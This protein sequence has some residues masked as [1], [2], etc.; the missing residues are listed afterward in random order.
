MK[1][2][3]KIISFPKI[4]L[5]PLL[6]SLAATTWSIRLGWDRPALLAALAVFMTAISVS[7]LAL[8]KSYYCRFKE[9]ATEEIKME[10]RQ[11]ELDRQH[12]L[13]L[14]H[15]AL[16]ATIDGVIVLSTDGKIINCNRQFAEMWNIS[17]EILATWSGPK[18]LGMMCELMSD[19]EEFL[20]RTGE[21]DDKCAFCGHH[22]CEDCKAVA[23]MTLLK[24]GRVI[25]YCSRPLVVEEKPAGR[26]WSFHDITPQ[27]LAHRA[28]QETN[29][30]LEAASGRA[31]EMALKA[32]MAS[33]AKSQFLANMSHEI[34]TPM[35][36]II[37]MT[38][39]L[40]Q[41]D[42]TSEQ[43][44]FARLLKSSGESLLALI[45]DILDF[46]KIEAQKLTL[47]KLD[48]NLRETMEEAAELL[49]FK[50]TEKNL[51]L[52]CLIPPEVPLF[53]RGDAL[54]LRQIFTNLAGN[55]IKFTAEGSVII[56]A[57]V[58]S[59][60]ENTVELKFTVTDTGIGIPAER[61][62]FLFN[63]FTQVDGST[64]RKFGGTGLGL[65][66][67]K[68]LA[69]MMGG[70]IGLESE[71]G[72]GTQFWFTA[73]FEKTGNIPAV[74]SASGCSVLIV[75]ARQATSQ[76][77]AQML[78]VAGCH[79][80]IAKNLAEAET[81]LARRAATGEPFQ[82]VLLGDFS[83]AAGFPAHARVNPCHRTL[84]FIRGTPFGV[85]IA[86]EKLAAEGFAAQLN[87]PFRFAQLDACLTR[88]L[89][90]KQFATSFIEKVSTSAARLRILVVDDNNTNLIVITKILEKLGHD[91]VPVA[92]GAEAINSLQR[93]EFDLLLMD[94]QMPEMDG[95]EATR[96]I[97]AG[98][99]GE[100]S[101]KIPIVALT[102]N[103]LAA[104]QQR[105]VTVGMDGYLGKPIQ[106]EELKAVLGRWQ[107]RTQKNE[108]L[109][110]I[111]KTQKINAPESLSATGNAVFNRADLMNRMLD[112][113]E[114][115]S[116]TARTFIEDL[117]Q[118]LA[119]IKSAVDRNDCAA[120]NSF[121]HRLKGAAGT[122]SGDAL[123]YL[124]GELERAGKN[125]DL[126]A[127]KKISA[128]LDAESAALVNSLQAEIL[129]TPSDPCGVPFAE[130]V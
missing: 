64:T 87:L 26:V 94:C 69:E 27:R 93:P 24:D 126:P 117:P 110:E 72:K 49:A 122:L 33:I 51:E 92:S 86:P 75:E 68:Q 40:M 28:L 106:L 5:L 111:P 17:S 3:A 85:R 31:N 120:I 15:A 42:L 77:I 22:N 129:D 2:P 8:G 13:S 127:A 63:S 38:S 108:K 21:L 45:N 80:G 116:L 43:K 6:L 50:A 90:D 84:K 109:A 36:G 7:I 95:Y 91:V 48:F 25:E 14:L 4:I 66:I 119:A 23:E 35:N 76:A 98:E 124:L 82:A 1:N 56:A 34:R 105:C 59:G 96:R 61:Q 97:R 18:V 114:M 62:Q 65:A 100:H 37:G 30:Q 11:A 9:I 88:V 41:T 79:F 130:K 10:R 81:A 55:A 12:S 73:T 52:A 67:S 102:A 123:Y 44:H 83:G 39:L 104:D 112:D 46:S 107:T 71:H 70:K 101:K 89:S 29:E 125:H 57:R 54:R 118:Q 99:A 115:A 47:E 128:Q 19:P 32:E 58:V 53:L 74:A 103:V 20:R 78:A 60:S 113:M 121:A 16:D